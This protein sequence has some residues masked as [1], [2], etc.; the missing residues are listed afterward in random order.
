[1]IILVISI[2]I[3]N[4]YDNDRLTIERKLLADDGFKPFSDD[5]NNAN[6]WIRRDFGSGYY[7]SYWRV[8]YRTV[9]DYAN[10]LNNYK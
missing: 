6:N 1:M 3:N 4:L 10:Y 2:I 5:I 9:N 7:D 8:Y